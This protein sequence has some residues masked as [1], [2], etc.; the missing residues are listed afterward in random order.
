MEPC[1]QLSAAGVDRYFEYRRV[2]PD[3]YDN[4][5]LPAYLPS[6][7]PSDLS[8]RI[9][10]YGCG[11]GQYLKALRELGYQ[12]LIGID[13]E[14]SAIAHCRADNLTVIH[15]DDSDA[16]KSL[17]ATADLVIMSH[18][19]EHMPKEMMVKVLSRIRAMLAPGG[20]LLIM[21]PNAQSSTGCYWAYEDFTHYALFTAGSLYYVLRAAGF[22]NVEFVD[23]DCIMGLPGWKVVGR[24][25]LLG[26]YRLQYNFWNKVTQSWTH[27]SFP[28]IF[29]YEIKALAC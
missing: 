26:A 14:Q 8:A 16:V 7:V 20:K 4:F 1:S 29:S 17:A 3:A 5:R 15:G 27:G 25:V 10:D 18:V 6:Y 9:I 21:V 12:A 22:S 28:M 19:L 11:Y 24:R 23:P 2:T 13:I